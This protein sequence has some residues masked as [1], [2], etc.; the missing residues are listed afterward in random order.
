MS[1]RGPRVKT[2]WEAG[3]STQVRDAGNALVHWLVGWRHLIKPS[4]SPHRSTTYFAMK[5]TLL[6]YLPSLLKSMLWAGMLCVVRGSWGSSV[7]SNRN[8][9]PRQVRKR[10]RP[11]RPAK[12]R[13]NCHWLC[14]YPYPTTST[15]IPLPNTHTHT[16]LTESPG[17]GLLDQR[18][19]VRNVSSVA[20]TAE[21]CPCV[22]VCEAHIPTPLGS[23]P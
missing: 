15:P 21:I 3:C 20:T 16:L 7:Q 13:Q 8:W 2:L 6:G 18:V 14:L 11:R 19:G 1:P 4:L 17:Q 10:L 9:S 12:G 23:L 22:T 5:A